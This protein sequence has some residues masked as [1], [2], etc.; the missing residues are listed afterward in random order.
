MR[1]TREIGD[2]SL[3]TRREGAQHDFGAARSP[4]HVRNNFSIRS[5]IL[6]HALKVRVAKDQI[7]LFS[8]QTKIQFLEATEVPWSTGMK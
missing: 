1:L 7:K 6:I 2:G 8:P 3:D 4:A 5:K